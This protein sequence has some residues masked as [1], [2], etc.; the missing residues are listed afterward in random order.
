M[1]K[2][3]TF[4]ERILIGKWAEDRVI[5]YLENQWI[6][7]KFTGAESIFPGWSHNI[8]KI[9]ST[10]NDPFL[11]T[12]RHFPDISAGE[13][14]VQIKYAKN[15]D[16]YRQI[17]LEKSSYNACMR[18]CGY[19]FKVLIIWVYGNGEIWGNWVQKLGELTEPKTQLN[20]SGTDFWLVD[21]SNLQPIDRFL[22]DMR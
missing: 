5:E 9:N 4:D 7:V 8:L 19:G 17:T 18:L 6:T 10:E 3:D 16:K 14:Y 21:K 2:L 12:I 20:G 1:T 13:V 11:E 22:D 15:A